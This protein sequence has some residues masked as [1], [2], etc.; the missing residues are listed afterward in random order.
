MS[1]LLLDGRPNFWGF[2]PFKSFLLFITLATALFWY[3]NSHL[4]GIGWLI[5]TMA[6]LKIFWIFLGNQCL[7]YCLFEIPNLSRHSHLEYCL[8]IADFVSGIW[9]CFNKLSFTLLVTKNWKWVFGILI[10]CRQ[11]VFAR[12]NFL[13]LNF[14]RLT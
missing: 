13:A 5:Q 11:N 9:F 7:K 4:F 10:S 12:L 1:V 3:L 14:N 2:I 8:F 6:D